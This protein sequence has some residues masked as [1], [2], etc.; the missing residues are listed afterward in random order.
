[1]IISTFRVKLNI[2]VTAAKNAIKNKLTNKYVDL[3]SPSHEWEYGH[4]Y[5]M[6]CIGNLS[7]VI[8]VFTYLHGYKKFIPKLIVNKTF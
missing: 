5:T 3:K 1:M 4:K 2:Q 7:K 8:K 6:D